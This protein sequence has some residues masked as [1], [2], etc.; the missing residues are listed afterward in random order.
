ML[1]RINNNQRDRNHNIL[2]GPFISPCKTIKKKKILKE[3]KYSIK[4]NLSTLSINMSFW[5]HLISFVSAASSNKYLKFSGTTNFCQFCKELLPSNSIELLEHCRLCVFTGFRDKFHKYM[6]VACT[7]YSHKRDNMRVHLRIHTG[8]KPFM[9]TICD[10]KTAQ[11]QHLKTHMVMIHN[12]ELSSD[13]LSNMTVSKS[14]T[15]AIY[16]ICMFSFPCK[17]IGGE[18]KKILSSLCTYRHNKHY[19]LSSQ[20]LRLICVNSFANLKG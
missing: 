18:I 13:I 3:H 6:C 20:L 5:T 19:L 12:T 17:F 1:W 15:I 9:C 11:K 14:W 8:E 4:L 16:L 2:S 7:Y 10:F